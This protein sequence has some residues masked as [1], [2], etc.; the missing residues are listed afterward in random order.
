LYPLLYGDGDVMGDDK[1][2]KIFRYLDDMSFALIVSDLSF[3]T[4]VV[5]ITFDV[6]AKEAQE[7][8]DEW[9]AK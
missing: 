5:E 6:S 1:K 4:Y 9:R 8:V 2:Q 3:T 7:V